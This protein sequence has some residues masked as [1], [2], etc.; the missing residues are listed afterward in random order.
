VSDRVE[1]A[2]GPI[3]RFA[4]RRERERQIPSDAAPPE[5]KKPAGSAG[6]LDVLVVL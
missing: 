4:L 3:V 6:G 2:H 1:N 5:I